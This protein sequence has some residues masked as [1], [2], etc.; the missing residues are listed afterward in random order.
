[1]RMS[2]KTYDNVR[3]YAEIIGH[4]LTFILAVSEIIGFRY[5][6]ELAGIV[7]ALNICIGGI[8]D[9]SRKRYNEEMEAENERNN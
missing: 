7:A 6:V 3:F 4:V 5:G 1:M 2:N 8:V 9:A